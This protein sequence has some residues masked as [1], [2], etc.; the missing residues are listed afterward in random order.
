MQIVL[1]NS[2][3]SRMCSGKP[4]GFGGSRRGIGLNTGHQGRLPEGSC[5]K[6]GRWG[7]L[8]AQEVGG[9]FQAEKQ[10]GYKPEGSRLP[11]ELGWHL[12]YLGSVVQWLGMSVLELDCWA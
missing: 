5:R 6:T 12:P 10:H 1:Q 2:K 3:D 8:H 11:R 4:S 9:K 7:Q